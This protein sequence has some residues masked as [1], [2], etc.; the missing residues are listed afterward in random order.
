MD[1][2][3]LRTCRR[4]LLGAGSILA[5]LMLGAC[6]TD[7]GERTAGGAA[8]GAASGAAIGA[9]AGGVGAIPGALIGGAVGAGTGAYTTP[10]EVKLPDPVWDNRQIG[11]GDGVPNDGQ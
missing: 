1:Q 7:P 11:T 8:T 6:G 5:L 3:V 9:L 2:S 4:N 10:K